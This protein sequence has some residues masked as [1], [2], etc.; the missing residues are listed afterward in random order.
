MKRSPY[1]PLL[2]IL[3]IAIGGVATTLATSS[4]PGLGLDLQGGVSVVLEP[5]GK[6]STEALDKTIGIIRRRVDAFGA[7]EPDIARQG[8]AIVV[9]IPGIKDQERALAIVGKTAELRFRPVIGQL[10]SADEQTAQDIFNASSTTTTAAPTTTIKGATTVPGATSTSV[11]GAS[12]AVAG[13]TTTAVAGA[14]TTA[15][16]GATTTAAAATTTTAA[17]AT[18]TSAAATT[19]IAASTT[20]A[21]GFDVAPAGGFGSFAIVA[22]AATTT[23]VKAATTA[24]ATVTTKASN[25]SSTIAGSTA[26]TLPGTATTIVTGATQLTPATVLPN[27]A[28]AAVAAAASATCVPTNPPQIPAKYVTTP[29]EKDTKDAYVILPQ[30]DNKSSS[31][32]Y[33]LA[34]ALLTGEI[35]EDAQA[36]LSNTGSWEVIADFTGSGSGQWDAMAAKC[37][38]QQIAIVLDGV[39][40]SAPTINVAQFNGSAQ[41]TGTFTESEAKDLATSLKFGSLPVQ[42][43]TQTVQTVSATLGRDSLDAGLLAG[44]VGLALV[45]LY[46]LFYYR[47]LGLVVVS[48][49]LLSGAL[50]WSLVTWLSATRGIALSLSGAVGI[51]VSVGVTVDSYVVFFERHART[52]S[53]AVESVPRASAVPGLQKSAW[54]T[55]SVAADTRLASSEPFVLW[56]LLTVGWQSA[57]SPSSSMLSTVT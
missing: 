13:A 7:A 51:I 53:A 54:R 30:D 17:A 3:A 20:V 44:F 39:V 23:V 47:T 34:P 37:V 15:V 48:G 14:T 21:P 11:A 57:A 40:E 28:A 35:I 29:I 8:D 18:T 50:M 12:T 31:P 5:V 38:N 1:L 27:D 9:Q 25:A 45:A 26:T 52:R 36:Q 33:Y 22:Q 46:M 56:Y 6:V 4:Q 10:P 49:L 24:A 55:R 2:A 19:T 41:I 16:A 42:L 43:K 32:R